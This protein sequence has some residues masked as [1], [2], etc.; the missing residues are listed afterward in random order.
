[1]ESLRYLHEIN[2]PWDEYT[3]HFA[4]RAGKLATLRYA[5]E[6]GCPFTRSAVAGAAEAGS[7]SCLKYL[8]ETE[9]IHALGLV[10]AFAAAM[11]SGNHECFAY[12]L[13][14][15]YRIEDF[16]FLSRPFTRRQR[17]CIAKA[18]FDGK[19]SLCVVHAVKHG[20]CFDTHLRR[21]AK[22][23]NFRLCEE[24]AV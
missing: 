11:L 7:L 8:L 5:L 6:N 3:V 13:R 2:C 18:N 19:F 24:L 9:G 16:S 20:I 17:K 22:M 21:F 12:L 10:S 1:M 4:A 15:G 23:Y 14:M